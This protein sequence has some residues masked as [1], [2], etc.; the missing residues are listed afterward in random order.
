M[1]GNGGRW[2]PI[3]ILTTNSKIHTVFYTKFS[4]VSLLVRFP[5]K[6]LHTFL[7]PIKLA[8]C[9]TNS[10]SFTWQL[11]NSI[12]TSRTDSCVKAW[13]F[14]T[15]SRSDSV[16]IFRVLS[17]HRE[18]GDGI[19]PWNAGDLSH[20]DAAVCPRRLYWILSPRK[21]QDMNLYNVCRRL[22]R[23]ARQLFVT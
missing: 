14:S 13:E 20:L 11:Y 5:D 21:P 15:V 6:S 19:S 8:G 23:A 10:F 3:F 16:A 7:I 12:Q 22:Q 4:Q 18:D 1:G 2:V 17:Q 9:P